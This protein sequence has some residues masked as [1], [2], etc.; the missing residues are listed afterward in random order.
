M[1]KMRRYRD[2]L[3]EKLSDREGPLLSSRTGRVR[4]RMV[5]RFITDSVRLL[6]RKAVRENLPERIAILK[7][8]MSNKDETLKHHAQLP[9]AMPET[10]KGGQN[11]IAP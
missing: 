7:A 3:I 5:P 4:D 9:Y 2:Y 11:L 10:G 1:R 8:G 6:K